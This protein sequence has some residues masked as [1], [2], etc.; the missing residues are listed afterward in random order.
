MVYRGLLVWRDS[1]MSTE[2]I[3]AVT[4]LIFMI[5]AAIWV[6]IIWHGMWTL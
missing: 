6:I 2:R 1:V 5:L 4:D 3:Q